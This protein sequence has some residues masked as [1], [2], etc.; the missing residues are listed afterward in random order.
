[1]KI[2]EAYEKLIKLKGKKFDDIFNEEQM[3][4]IIK[5]K[6]KSGQ[7]IE[8]AI[9]LKNTPAALDF[10]DGELKTN[11]CNMLGKPLET[12][13]I[14]QV[15]SMMDDIINITDFKQT[16]LLKK[17]S[18][19]LYVPISKEGKPTE[20]FILDVIH[21]NLLTEKYE[22][23]LSQLEQDYYSICNQF[24]EEVIIQ[25]G[26]MHTYSGE[27]IQIRT[28]DSKPYHPIYMNGREISDK[29]RAFYFKKPFMKSIIVMQ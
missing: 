24:R 17:I 6:G 14:T 18:N 7:I 9:G 22:G 23:V 12:M 15:A 16:K 27:Y 1:M 10:E 4:D 25:K 3:N 29:Y 8:L 2:K 28:K 26:S 13:F 5:N 21:I 11:K 20:W 19:M